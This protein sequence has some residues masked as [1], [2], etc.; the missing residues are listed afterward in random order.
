MLVADTSGRK[1][2]LKI[3][4]KYN[5]NIGQILI[6]HCTTMPSKYWVGKFVWVKLRTIQKNPSIM[7]RFS[8]DQRILHVVNLCE[9]GDFAG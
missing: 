4:K 8:E 1:L 9:R 6:F 3:C 2:F 5:A 7:D